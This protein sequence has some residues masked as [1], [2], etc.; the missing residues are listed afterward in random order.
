M[1]NGG[2]RN[3]NTPTEAEKSL[4]VALI[5]VA[6]TVFAGLLALWPGMLSAL[7]H[8]GVLLFSIIGVAIL[9]FL[10]VSMFFG[11]RGYVHGPKNADWRDRFNLQ[12]VFGAIAVVLILVLA[13]IIFATIEPSPNEKF[14]AK[15]TALETRLSDIKTNVD[16]IARDVGSLTNGVADLKNKGD[17]AEKSIAVLDRASS[18]YSNKLGEIDR[19]LKLLLDRVQKLENN[20]N[21]TKP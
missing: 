8:A 15:Q 7:N 2:N 14:A 1:S 9:G 5:A 18:D 16:T 4:A 11:G 20:A 19:S 21:Q 17:A 6:A 10:A 3:L 13:S 12:A